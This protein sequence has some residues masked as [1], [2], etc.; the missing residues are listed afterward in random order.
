MLWLAVGLALLLASI[1]F[2]T[3]SVVW[4]QQ[5]TPLQVYG[6]IW[7]ALRNYALYPELIGSWEQWRAHGDPATTAD[8]VRLAN[9]MLKS[10]NDPYTMALTTEQQQQ[11]TRW[12]TTE[13]IG[14]GVRIA[15]G[16]EDTDAESCSQKGERTGVSC[17][18]P[19]IVSVLNNSPAAEAGIIAGDLIVAVD[20][21]STSGKP[22][23]EILS[24]MHGKNRASITLSIE[25]DGR[26][27]DVL[28]KRRFVAVPTAWSRMLDHD[29]GYLRLS[30][31]GS[32]SYHSATVEAERLKKARAV[33][34]DLRDNP[35]GDISTTLRLCAMFTRQAVLTHMESRLIGGDGCTKKTVRLETLAGMVEGADGRSYPQDQIM[36]PS[37]WFEGKPIVVLVNENTASAA[38]LFAGALRD[39]IGAT[40]LG[41]R[42]FGKGVFQHTINLPQCAVTVRVTSGKFFCPNGDWAGDGARDKR[43]IEPSVSVATQSKVFDIGSDRD[44][45][46]QAAVHILEQ[47][48]NGGR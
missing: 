36:L 18:F 4:R 26:Q 13:A 46:L 41:A 47:K 7:E 24:R 25:H 3:Y 10:L 33:V 19:T 21:W 12:E 31:F 23:S 42:T 38:E 5:P 17:Q 37:C 27:Q 11:F 2:L 44:L 30:N 39:G 9:E 14:V 22:L 48:L 20:G 34:V 40:V 35:G 6:Y 43:G 32:W 45:Q 29:V 28:L 15:A 16:Y 8:A 1:V